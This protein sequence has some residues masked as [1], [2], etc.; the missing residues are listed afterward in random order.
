ME[1]RAWATFRKVWP[2]TKIIVTSPPLEFEDYPNR[3]ISKR[4][5]ITIML[6][7]LQRIRL[8]ANEGFQ[9]PQK[10]PRKVLHC[11]RQ[12]VKLGYTEHLKRKNSKIISI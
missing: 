11:Y 8:Y 4:Y 5:V 1:R 10:I 6:G 3:L 9:I 2:Q 12:L 7:D